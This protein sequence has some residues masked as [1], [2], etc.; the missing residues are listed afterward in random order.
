MSRVTSRRLRAEVSAIVMSDVILMRVSACVQ[1]N[2]ALLLVQQLPLILMVN[3][4]VTI[5][6]RSSMIVQVSLNDERAMLPS[7]SSS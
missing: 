6:R 2:A 7:S 5:D 1:Y 3:N 4:K